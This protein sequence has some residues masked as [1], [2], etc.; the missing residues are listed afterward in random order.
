MLKKKV[1]DALNK[2]INEEF[3][4]AYLYLSM[5]AYTEQ[6]NLMGFAHWFKIQVQEEWAHMVKIQKHIQDRG[7]EVRFDAIRQPPQKWNSPIDIVQGAVNHEENITECFNKLMDIVVAEK[8]YAAHNLVNW[9]IDE[10]VEEENT[11]HQVLE[12]LKLIGDSGPALLMLDNELGQR[13]PVPNPFE[14]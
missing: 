12:K 11:A 3:Y 10:Q 5:A 9:F 13:A 8:D 7:G 14:G 1:E 4:S 2:Q 6:R